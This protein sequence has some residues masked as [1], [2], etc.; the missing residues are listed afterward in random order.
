MLSDITVW[1]KSYGFSCEQKVT[2]FLLPNFN[3]SSIAPVLLVNE[4]L[5]ACI[6]LVSTG[7]SQGLTVPCPCT[8]PQQATSLT[9]NNSLGIS[10]H[11][12]TAAKVISC[13][14]VQQHCS[15]AKLALN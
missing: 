2:S 13:M 10:A 1:R 15:P 7:P 8:K 4:P 3:N 6:K 11:V 9:L 14:A 5:T 12:N